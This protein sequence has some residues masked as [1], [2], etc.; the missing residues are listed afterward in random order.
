MAVSALAGTVESAT[1]GR[2]EAFVTPGLLDA[3]SANPSQLFD[4]IV[5]ARRGKRSSEVAGEVQATQRHLPGRGSVLRRQFRST[6][7]VAAKLSGRQIVRLADRRWV[8]AI[9]RDEPVALT[10]S[11]TST[12]VETVGATA[13]WATGPAAGSYP[14]IAIVDSGVENGRDDFG[15]RLLAQVSFVSA[16]PNGAGDGRGHG[17]LVASIAASSADGYSGAEPRA[18]LVSLDVLDDNGG[19]RTSDLIAACD[20]IL[21][22]RLA[23]NIRVANFSLNAGSPGTPWQY[24]PLNKAVERLWLSGVTVV[25]ASGNY[26]TSAATPTGVLF[27]PANNPFV[28]TVGASGTKRTASVSDDQAA[29]WSAWGYTNEGFLKPE[30]AAPGRYMRGAV[31]EAGTMK[32]E[33]EERGVGTGY[34]WMSGTSFAA[35]VV[36]GL[37]ANILA[38]NPSW[39]PNQVKGALMLTA[40]QPSGYQPGGALGVGIVNGPA[41]ATSP[42][43]ANPNE[44]LY[45]FV[46]TDPQTGYPVFDAANWEQT[47]AGNASWASASWS[48][49]SWSSASWSSAS[50]S[51][52]SWA[53]ASWASASWASASWASASWASASWA[54]NANTSSE[55]A[56]E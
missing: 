39:T 20:W 47:A 30:V 22:N 19:G 27:A 42:G 2:E 44:A 24:D 6:E 37:A 41:A 54:N 29:H 38:R 50:W 4:V 51:S 3:A 52:A 45:Q 33:F 55:E 21:A 14:T 43:F 1:A 8:A 26:G 35:P 25:V 48:S 28:I 15:S 11:S 16:G 23:Y 12:W 10:G 40:G 32:S 36:S 31:P 9:V 49:A 18:N 7:G 46:Q 17:T 53:S 56:V 34:M 5:T 13:N